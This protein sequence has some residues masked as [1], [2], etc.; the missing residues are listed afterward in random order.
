[1]NN[2]YLYGDDRNTEFGEWFVFEVNN[3]LGIEHC[4]AIEQGKLLDAN[5]AGL[6]K[7]VCYDG[8][9]AL[10]LKHHFQSFE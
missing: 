10:F 1:M 8:E 7:S 5:C 6:Q 9:C 2:T 3:S 4:V